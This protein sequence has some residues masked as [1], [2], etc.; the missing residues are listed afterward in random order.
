MLNFR[1]GI[2]KF[3]VNIQITFTYFRPGIN[4]FQQIISHFGSGINQIFLTRCTVTQ[5]SSGSLPAQGV[6]RTSRQDGVALNSQ[7][8]SNSF[9][10]TN[11]NHGQII[12]DLQRLRGVAKS[13]A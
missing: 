12:I 13:W 11:F 9:L 1:S 5:S 2:N 3:S 6:S 4:K 8:I 10:Q 7:A